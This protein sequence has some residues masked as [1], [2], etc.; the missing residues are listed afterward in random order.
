MTKNRVKFENVIRRK[1]IN[2]M[3]YKTEKIYDITLYKH[4][5]LYNEPLANLFF[6]LIIM[7]V[8]KAMKILL[9]L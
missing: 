2:K 7:M 3:Q 6:H 5:H 8:Y 1:Y 9:T 4:I